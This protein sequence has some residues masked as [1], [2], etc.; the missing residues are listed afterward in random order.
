MKCRVESPA[1]GRAGGKLLIVGGDD[2][3][4]LE[5]MVNLGIGGWIDMYICTLSTDSQV[6]YS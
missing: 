2:G 1:S 6:S 5:A 4:P 3:G